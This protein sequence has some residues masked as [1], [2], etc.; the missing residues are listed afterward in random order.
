MMRERERRE[1]ETGK[2]GPTSHFPCTPAPGIT[3]FAP[4]PP[5]LHP[6]PIKFWDLCI[7]R[8]RHS[9]AFFTQEVILLPPCEVLEQKLVEK[10]TTASP[11]S[12]GKKITLHPVAQKS[13]GVCGGD[14]W[15]GVGDGGVDLIPTCVIFLLK[16]TQEPRGNVC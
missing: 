12:R 3:G 10:E 4:P 11:L 1:E 2:E 6:S 13:W 15:W 14:N 5:R 8:C 16:G 7:F 9:N